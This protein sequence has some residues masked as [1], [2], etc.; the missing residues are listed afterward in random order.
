MYKTGDIVR[1]K[2]DVQDELT[3]IFME[4]WQGRVID[5]ANDAATGEP[6][7]CVCCF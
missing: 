1:V 3:G 6:L 5:F 2:S 7:V 4:N